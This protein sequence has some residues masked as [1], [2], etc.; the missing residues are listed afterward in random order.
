MFGFNRAEANINP[1]NAIHNFR[2]IKK[3]TNNAKIICVI[4]ADAYGH[5]AV[6]LGRLFESLGADILAV[7]CLEEALNL[8]RGGCHSPILILGSTPPDATDELIRNDIIQSV[9]SKEYAIALNDAAKKFDNKLHIHI[10]LDTGM[11][12]L[13][14]YA[15]EG[16]ENTAANDVAEICNL[17]NLIPDGIFTHFSEAESPDTSF[18]DK[19]FSSFMTVVNILKEEKNITFEFCHCANSAAVVNY[20]RAH[21]NCVRPGLILYGYSPTGNAIP[22]LDL[23]PVMTLKCRIADVRFVK[24]GDFLSYNRNFRAERDMKVAVLGFGYADGLP[25]ALSSCGV[26]LVKGKRCPILGNVCMDLTLV[27]VSEVPDVSPFDEAVI[28]GSSGDNFLS[29]DELAKLSGTISYELLTSVSKRVLR[30]YP[31]ALT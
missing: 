3:F 21:L 8:R 13:G 6:V 1:D 26:V 16:S 9:A 30:T 15:H 20:K 14:L 28:F 7:A 11:S 22:G 29:P 19:Q 18:T 17:S 10:K 12:R 2:E 24:S 25:R 5:G 31:N 27:D 23:K 4:K